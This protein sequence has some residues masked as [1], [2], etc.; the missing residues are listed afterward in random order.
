MA[1]LTLA[2]DEELLKRARIRALEQGTSVNALLRE[3]LESFAGEGRAPE[4]ARG[5][6]AVTERAGASSGPEGRSWT[7]DDAHAR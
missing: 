4:G 1:N 6:L 7:R 3:Y 5:F 2:I